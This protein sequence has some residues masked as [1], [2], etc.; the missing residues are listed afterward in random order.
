M[1][2]HKFGSLALGRVG[3]L[4]HEII[5]ALCPRAQSSS[6]ACLHKFLALGGEILHKSVSFRNTQF[7]KDHRC[8]RSQILPLAT[9]SGNSENHCISA[10]GRKRKNL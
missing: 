10:F 1:I 8:D 6:K 3:S 2:L 9:K 7:V 4:G 5:G